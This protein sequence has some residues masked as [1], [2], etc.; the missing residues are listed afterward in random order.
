MDL[1]QDVYADFGFNEIIVKLSTRPENRVGSDEVW[2]KAEHALERA[3]HAADHW[4]Q[5][6]VEDRAVLLCRCAELLETNMPELMTMLVREAGNPL[7][8]F[9]MGWHLQTII[10]LSQR[11]KSI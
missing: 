11:L 5:K 4:N 1:L 9:M 2:D 3:D 7:A 10:I 6:P 8:F